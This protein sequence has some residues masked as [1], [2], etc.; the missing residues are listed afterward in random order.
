LLQAH[1]AKLAA[2][3]LDLKCCDYVSWRL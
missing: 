1:A 3:D 2:H